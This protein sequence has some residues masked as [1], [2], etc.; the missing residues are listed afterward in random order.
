MRED[1]AIVVPGFAFLLQESPAQDRTNPQGFEEA[2]GDPLGR[3][4]LGHARAPQR[5]VRVFER[6]EGFEDI[7]ALLLPVEQVGRRGGGPVEHLGGRRVG[8]E[9][10]QPIVV[11]KIERPKKEDV[12]QAEHRDVRPQAEA[13]GDDEEGGHRLPLPH[14]AEGEAS[15]A[16]KETHKERNVR[17]A[18]PVPYQANW[19]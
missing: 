7:A 15:V 12:G 13:E 16:Q 5:R 1:D 2:R 11:R 17:A 10:D 8:P 9:P 18:F 19:T 3:H 4:A 6:D 14:G